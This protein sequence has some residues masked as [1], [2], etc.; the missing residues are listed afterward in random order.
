[1]VYAADHLID[2]H[3][4]SLINQADLVYVIE[5]GRVTQQGSP[6]ELRQQGGWFERFIR[7]AEDPAAVDPTLTEPDPV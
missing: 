2:R 7:S 6:A 1:V 4:P 5:N 3:R